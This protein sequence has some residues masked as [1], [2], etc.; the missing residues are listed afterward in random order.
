M[1]EKKNIDSHKKRK[2]TLVCYGDGDQI[3]GSLT[4][5]T[6]NVLSQVTRVSMV[7]SNSFFCHVHLCFHLISSFLN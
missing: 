2:T 1:F 3:H 6:V 5:N 7:T 4:Q